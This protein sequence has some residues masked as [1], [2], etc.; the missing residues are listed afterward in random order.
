MGKNQKH[1]FHSY[2]NIWKTHFLPFL[3]LND[4][5]FWIVMLLETSDKK[6]LHG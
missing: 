4:Q 1:E 5:L 2:N 3:F 6:P